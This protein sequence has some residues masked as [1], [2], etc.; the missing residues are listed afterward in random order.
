MNRHADR[1]RVTV[2]IPTVGRWALLEKAVRAARMQRDVDAHVLVALDG[3]ETWPAFLNGEDVT[4]LASPVR[5]G[6]AG[7]RNAALAAASGDWVAFLDDDDLWAPDKLARQVRAAA[8]T[9][10]AYASA[11]LVDAGLQPLSLDLALAPDRLAD[12]MLEHNP[13]P[14]CASN[15]LVR[16]EIARALEFDARLSHFADWDFALRLIAAARGAACPE[17]LVAYVHHDEAMHVRQIDGAGQE[18]ARFRAKHRGVGRELHDLHVARW[19]GQGHRRGGRGRRAAA[20][21]LGAAVRHR[22]TVD[23]GRAAGALLGERALHAARRRRAAPPTAPAP[24]WLSL[25]R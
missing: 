17:P 12:A 2:V 11:A 16:L 13:I 24:E 5:R 4:V 14:A 15:L 19:I 1:P 7:A 18:F 8:G 9:G 6:V 23:L 22:S 25:Y 3:H 20:V 10:F 21:Y